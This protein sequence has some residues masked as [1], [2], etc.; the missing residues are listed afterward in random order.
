MWEL[1]TTDAS[2]QNRNLN[3]ESVGRTLGLEWALEKSLF[4]LQHLSGGFVAGM[5]LKWEQV[6]VEPGNGIWVETQVQTPMQMYMLYMA[7]PTQLTFLS[8][9]FQ[10]IL[11]YCLL[12]RGVMRLTF[13]N[14]FIHLFIRL[15]RQRLRSYYV[16]ITIF[17]L[18][19][20]EV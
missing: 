13:Q 1:L 8:L 4:V 5:R 19:I 3:H 11:Y 10:W 14:G 9:D 7:C 16:S 20:H 6:I 15:I 12:H 18:E 2:W 17:T